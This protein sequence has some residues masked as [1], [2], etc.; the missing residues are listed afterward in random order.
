MRVAE[1]LRQEFALVT[2]FEK[3]HRPH[4]FAPVPTTARVALAELQSARQEF[5]DLIPQIRSS[6]EQRITSRWNARQVVCHVASWAKEL[7]SE[8]ELALSGR[9]PEYTIL[10]YGVGGPTEWNEEQLLLRRDFTIDEAV[11]EY[12][13]ETAGLEVAIESTASTTLIEVADFALHTAE[14]RTALLNSVADAVLAKCSHDR[15]HM[16]SLANALLSNEEHAPW[17]YA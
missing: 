11:L 8:V 14:N 15:H 7:R 10:F 2:H 4:T 13:R 12:T 16:R 6:E 1:Q 17:L 9:K 5:E 3:M